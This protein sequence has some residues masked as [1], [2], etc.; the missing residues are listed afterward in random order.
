VTRRVFVRLL[1]ITD[2]WPD[3]FLYVFFWSRTCD[4][5]CFCTSSSDHGLVTRRVFV[6]LLL[7][8]D[9]WPD[10][11]YPGVLAPVIFARDGG[12]LW[13]LVSSW[14]LF[15][16]KGF[17]LGDYWVSRFSSWPWGSIG[18]PDFLLDLG[19]RSGFPGHPNHKTRGWVPN[20]SWWPVGLVG[21]LHELTG[22]LLPWPVAPQRIRDET[23]RDWLVGMVAFPCCC[24][25]CNHLLTDFPNHCY[26]TLFCEI[27]NFLGGGWLLD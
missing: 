19:G 11:F 12:F 26:V 18:F 25:L 15:F 9:L 27:F 6:R 24:F 7:I 8:T 23:I 5:T 13:P 1:L 21:V 17:F 4:P 16:Q 10:V 2:L 3:V 22:L 20:C 14:S